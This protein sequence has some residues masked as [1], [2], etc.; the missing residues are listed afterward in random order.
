MLKSIISYVVLDFLPGSVLL[1]EVSSGQPP[2][3]GIAPYGLIVRIPQ[4]FRET[5]VPDTPSAY[6]KLYTECW[7]GE[8]DNRPTISQ[9]VAKLKVLNNSSSQ[10]NN[11]FSKIVDELINLPNKTGDEVEKQEILN[12]L[13]NHSVTLKEIYDWLLNDQNNPN[14]IVLLGDFNIFGIE[15]NVDRKKAFE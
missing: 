10:I 9:V 3:E 11:N 7:N 6:V 8:P 12:Y 15:I 1:W 5:P 4:G 14:S 13:K 2:F